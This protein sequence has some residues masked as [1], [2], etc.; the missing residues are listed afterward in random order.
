MTSS[1]LSSSAHEKPGD[2]RG[3]HEPGNEIRA[4]NHEAGKFLDADADGHGAGGEIEPGDG[5]KDDEEKADDVY[6][7]DDGIF[8]KA[9][10]IRV[11]LG[12]AGE[13]VDLEKHFDDEDGDEDAADFAQDEAEIFPALEPPVGGDAFAI[14][15]RVIEGIGRRGGRGFHFPPQVK[16]RDFTQSRAAVWLYVWMAP[17]RLPR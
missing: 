6:G 8:Q 16:R 1:L 10:K 4:G 15:A 5:M 11:G 14:P 7:D 9:L 17:A 12:A 13:G 2:N 3:K